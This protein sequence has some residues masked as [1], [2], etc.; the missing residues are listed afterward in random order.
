MP[1]RPGRVYI[2]LNK[3]RAHPL[4]AAA[5]LDTLS[6]IP[7]RSLAAAIV[8]ALALRDAV[9]AIL[10]ILDTARSPRRRDGWRS[11]ESA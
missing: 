8:G 9:R 7:L 4:P 11:E 5:M 10:F 1:L 2:S 6:Q 3:G